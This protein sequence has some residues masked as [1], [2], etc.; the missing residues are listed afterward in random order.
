M[1]G[2]ML[3]RYQILLD[4]WLADHLKDLAERYDFSFSEM[5]RIALC[6]SI[7]CNAK[8]KFPKHKVKID[9]ATLEKLIKSKEIIDTLPSE[10]VHQITSDIY[11]E[12]RKVVELWSKS[13]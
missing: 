2:I 6:R 10:K 7:L 3:K 1:G 5:V 8:V 12:A 4:E 13:T 9:N 11:F